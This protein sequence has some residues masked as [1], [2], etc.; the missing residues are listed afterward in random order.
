MAIPKGNMRGLQDI[1]TLSGKVDQTF[2]PYRAYL[3]IGGLEMEKARRNKERESALH[4]VK[5][6]EER[7]Q[8]IDAEKTALLRNLERKNSNAQPADTKKGEPIGESH[9]KKSGF[10][11]KY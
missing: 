11:I 4:R 2:Q 5:I 10:R 1:R 9:P 8:A 6:I 7:F 3:R